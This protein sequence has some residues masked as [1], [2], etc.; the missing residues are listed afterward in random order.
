MKTF[1]KTLLILIAIPVLF[2]VGAFIY[3]MYLAATGQEYKTVENPALTESE[4]VAEVV[5]APTKPSY[6]FTPLPEPLDAISIVDWTGTNNLT[7]V[8]NG[9]ITYNLEIA[10]ALDLE[11]ALTLHKV[12]TDSGSEYQAVRVMFSALC[13]Q[14][15]PEERRTF[16][17]KSGA[18]FRPKWYSGGH[19]YRGD[20]VAMFYHVG[21]SYDQLYTTAIQ[22]YC[23]ILTDKEIIQA[24]KDFEAFHEDLSVDEWH[25]RV[26]DK[27]S[28]FDSTTLM[29]IHDVIKDRFLGQR[30]YLRK[31]IRELA[32]KNR[33]E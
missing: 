3:G 13:S 18:V 4:T 2:L 23:E 5:E 11:T 10:A 1:F 31:R 26:E 24:L 28:Q 32:E 21:Y 25:I 27:M 33:E 20:F 7:P 12:L 30:K 17:S 8:K 14:L 16:V 22:S 15:P 6:D 9:E 29:A 19:G